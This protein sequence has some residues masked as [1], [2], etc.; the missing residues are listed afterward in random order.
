MSF[1]IQHFAPLALLWVLIV[2]F[3]GSRDSTQSYREALLCA[4]G[5]AAISMI[6]AWMVPMPVKLLRY[7][8]QVVALFFLVDRICECSRAVTWRIVIWYV[9]ITVG[10]ALLFSLVA[11]ILKQPVDWQPSR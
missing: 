11:D 3:T 9:V 5:L 4:C 7:P 2:I 1:I 10:F 8:A 6:F